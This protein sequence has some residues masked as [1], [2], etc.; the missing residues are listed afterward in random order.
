MG[1]L[2]KRLKKR[3]FKA[4]QLG[5]QNIPLSEQGLQKT[6]AAAIAQCTMYN[7]QVA[8]LAKV[9]CLVAMCSQEP[10]AIDRN[11]AHP[12]NQN[13]AVIPGQV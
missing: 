1:H 11:T 10:N 6:A 13:L 3:G 9:G 2:E 5:R 7:V 8:G 4:S 12:N